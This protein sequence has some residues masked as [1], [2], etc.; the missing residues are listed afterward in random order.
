MTT[1]AWLQIDGEMLAKQTHLTTIEAAF[2]TG[3]RPPRYTDP[4]KARKA[5]L[6]RIHRSSRLRMPLNRAS[7]RKL[8][9]LRTDLDRWLKGA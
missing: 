7:G 2:Y 8:D 9:F 3:Y 4:T 5:F 6:S 1:A